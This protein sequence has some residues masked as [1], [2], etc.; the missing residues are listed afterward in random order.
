MK[1]KYDNKREN[2]IAYQQ[3]KSKCFSFAQKF[4]Y[5]FVVVVIDIQS[6]KKL[7]LTDT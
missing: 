7:Y 1:R 6:K 4:I 2:I 5:I 3:V